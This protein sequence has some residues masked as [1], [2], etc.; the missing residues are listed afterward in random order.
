M[1]I[2]PLQF[3]FSEGSNCD[4]AIAMG[5]ETILRCKKVSTN[6]H[7]AAI[8][9]SKAYDK[10]THKIMIN[11]LRKANV[12]EPVV[13][14][15]SCMFDQTYVRVL[16]GD[17]LIDELVIGNGERQGGVLPSLLFSFHINDVVESIRNINKIRV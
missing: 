9:L 6:V 11:K 4:T 10:I 15:L 14:I 7:C 8:D 5:K 3:R 2:T 12:P 17:Y 16:F 1:K 13:M